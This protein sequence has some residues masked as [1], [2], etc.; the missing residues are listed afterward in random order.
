MEHPGFF[1]RAG[2]FPLRAVAAAAEA[3]AADGV[4]PDL[5][6]KDV[7]PLDSAGQGDISFLDNRKY[8][9]I[10]AHTGASACL[11]APKFACS[12]ANRRRPAWSRPSPIAASPG[13]MTLF[14]PDALK[15]KAAIEDAGSRPRHPDPS[16][17]ASSSLGAIVEP[18]AVIGPEARIGSGTT[19]AAGAV[20]GY[21]VHVGRDCYH[22]PKRLADP[23][24]SR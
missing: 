19:I 3:K 1:E 13:C 10:F 14:Y 4:D 11:V 24:P 17:R 9:P 23:C 2:P 5:P 21:R 8:L 6:I 22:R 20:I 7:R 15:P 16:E 18:G 12:R